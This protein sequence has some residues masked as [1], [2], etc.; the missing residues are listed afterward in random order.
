MDFK[1]KCFV[2]RQQIIHI[3]IVV[4]TKRIERKPYIYREWNEIRNMP[5]SARTAY[6]ISDIITEPLPENPWFIVNS[7]ILA[8]GSRIN[9]KYRLGC[10]IHD[11]DV[12]NFSEISLRAINL[13]L[14]TSSDWIYHETL[15]LLS[16]HY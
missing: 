2:C 10:L 11:E 12:E 7:K 4:I 15:S 14:R 5:I 9:S 8:R 3:L 1:C 13:I 16:F 6:L